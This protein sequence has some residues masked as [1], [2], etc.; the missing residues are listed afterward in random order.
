MTTPRLAV[1]DQPID[2]I[3]CDSLI[4]GVTKDDSGELGL[5]DQSLDSDLAVQLLASA[6]AIRMSAGRDEVRT[7]PA[8]AGWAAEAIILVGLPGNGADVDDVR[9]AAGLGTRHAGARARLAISLGGPGP[10]HTQAAIEGALLGGWRYRHRPVTDEDP[11]WSELTIR[12]VID[13]EGIARAQSRALAVWRVRDLV[14]TPPNSLYPETFVEEITKTVGSLPIDIEVYDEARLTAEGF[15]GHLGVGGGSDRPPRLMALRY[16]A[17]TDLPHVSLVGKGITFDSGGLSLKPA[18]SM[19]GMKYDMTGA[20]TAAHAVIAA[21]E[22]GLAVRATAWLCL[23]ENM[24]SGRAQRP[25]DVITI[26]GGKTVEVLNTDA[27]GRLVLADGLQ[28][29]SA[30]RPDLIIDIATLTGAARVALGERYAALMGDSAAIQLVQ[31]A[32]RRAGELVWPL[33]LAEELRTG[34]KSEVADIANIATGSSLGG[35]L[36]AGLFLR[37]FVGSIEHDGVSRTIPWAHLDIAGPAS[38][39]GQAYG[40]TPKGPTGALTRT[41]IELMDGFDADSVRESGE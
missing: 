29:A 9:F 12:G 18:Q 11:S 13:Q 7:I 14:N 28:A 38:N 34:L 30:E 4:L 6:R 2:S 16:Q 20:A 31:E 37:E 27:E 24:P 23:A 41:L 25:G 40:F 5:A 21:A 22:L 10:L 36:V 39:S 32:S 19:I 8:P 3:A 17:A 35:S 26:H 15:G 33:P 1:T